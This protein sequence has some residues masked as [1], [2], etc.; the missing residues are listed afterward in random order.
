MGGMARDRG[1][2]TTARLRATVA[3]VLFGVAAGASLDCTSSPEATNP[4]P[5]PSG[6]GE[7][8]PA[9]GHLVLSGVELDIPPRALSETVRLSVRAGE[10]KPADFDVSGEV[11]AF[12]PAGISFAV[13]IGVTFQTSSA[14]SIVFWSGARIDVF[15][16]L[17]TTIADGKTSARTTH[18][19][20]GFVGARKPPVSS[21]SCEGSATAACGSCG[22]RSRTCSAGVWSDW[23]ACGAEGA[24]APNASE[25]CAG[26]GQ[27][28]CG[29]SC[30]WGACSAPQACT[31]PASEACGNCGTRAR[32]CNGG[33]WSTWSAC[34]GEGACALDATQT[35]GSGGSQVCVGACQWGECA[36]QTCDG[37]A[38]EACG[39][40]G[41]RSRTCTN[42]VW[43]SW[44]ACAGEGSCT[45]A[46]TR[47]CET[48]G[49]QSC[50]ASCEWGACEGACAGPS[51]Q[52]CGT[53]GTQN[54]TCANGSWSAWS[55][56]EEG[57]ACVPNTVRACTGGAQTCGQSCQWNTC[58]PGVTCVTKRVHFESVPT[59][60]CTQ[61]ATI[62]YPDFYLAGN[63]GGSI[64]KGISSTSPGLRTFFT[65]DGSYTPFFSAQDANNTVY[66]SV[67]PSKAGTIQRNGNWL[68]SVEFEGARG[69]SGRTGQDCVT[70]PMIA[71]SCR[72][73]TCL[74][75]STQ[76]CGNCGTRTRTCTNGTWSGYSACTNEGV[77]VPESAQ[78]CGSNGTQTCS[79]SCQ[80]SGCTGQTCEGAARESCGTCASRTR[81][82]SNGVWSPWSTCAADPLCGT[83]RITSGGTHSCAVKTDGS[84][85]CWGDNASGKATPPAGSFVQVSAG[86][87]FTC[88][89]K[90]DQTLVCWGSND[91]GA[92]SPPTG[93]F[94]QLSAGMTSACG[95]R[96]DGTVS[97]W[98]STLPP[99]TG[100]FQQVSVGSGH[101]CG[102]KTN[103]ALGC[104]GTGG[105]G[106][107]TPP[108]GTFGQVAAG[109]RYHSCGVKGD[110]TMSCWGL[111]D[112][113][114]RNFPA[115]SYRQVTAGNSRTCGIR[116]DGTVVCWGLYGNAA[117]EAPQGTFREISAGTTAV[118][119]IRTDGA[120]VCWGSNGYGQA[121][122]PAG[123]F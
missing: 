59:A 99:P 81:S 15:E 104:W 17:D 80:W 73:T 48:G 118:C 20:R 13:P 8:G 7:V 83:G 76:A 2:G 122:A 68:T 100:S 69:G 78:A 103:G 90:S 96:T 23:S 102:V 70:T 82:C 121:T 51:A 43:S 106:Q 111:N 11:Y 92:A 86:D 65:N 40:C 37:A 107:T 50:T 27:R 52:A 5:L 3:V 120:A 33:A 45:A 46:A 94:V 49:T 112:E 58:R 28:V 117:G 110:G 71:V 41:S 98:G 38:S 31:G 93:T 30:Q 26:G 44:S 109:W 74:G 67:D 85:V 19:S 115:A 6:A 79:S 57:G 97:C 56:C 63:V 39:N 84:L 42:G 18:F 123:T 35:C 12:E 91:T 32:T 25:A 105:S 95:V 64:E 108:T 34:T 14:D 10:P 9:G 55:T 16:P 113:Q 47:S 24:C 53:C 89:L 22:V 60:V 75:S 72:G 87:A 1:R 101:A 66:E 21:T 29:G 62:E 88:G 119:G 61:N 36:G 54:R 77:C 116:V 114:Q 4:A